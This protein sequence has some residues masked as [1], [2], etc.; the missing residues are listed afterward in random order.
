MSLKKKIAIGVAGAMATFA[1]LFVFLNTT[2]EHIDGDGM[3]RKLKSISGSTAVDCGTVRIGEPP[4]TASQCVMDAFGSHKPF[5]VRYDIRGVDTTLAGGLAQGKDGKTYAIS[6]MGDTHDDRGTLQFAQQVN[7]K[8][9]PAPS[10]IRLT[11]SG[12]VTC[13]PPSESK[14]QNLSDPQAEPY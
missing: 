12:R 14:P 2:W 1:G 10:A 5:R 13:F 8:A 4:Q 11:D 3:E 6:F 9:C 7:V